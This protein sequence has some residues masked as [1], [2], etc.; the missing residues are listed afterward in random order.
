MRRSSNSAKQGF[1]H[2]VKGRWWSF[3]TQ[4]CAK[5]CGQ[6]REAA[7]ASIGPGPTDRPPASA[8]T[9]KNFASRELHAGVSFIA[10]LP[11][12]SS[13]WIEAQRNGRSS[14]FRGGP[15]CCDQRI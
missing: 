7:E 3:T 14:L 6:N 5:K 15:F 1:V 11:Q 4:Y 2:L 12:L 8:V 9:A 10:I 13:P